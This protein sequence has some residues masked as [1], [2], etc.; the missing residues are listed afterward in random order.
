MMKKDVSLDSQQYYYNISSSFFYE[1]K[2][3]IPFKNKRLLVADYNQVV[4]VDAETYPPSSESVLMEQTI[5]L[6]EVETVFGLT[7]A[8]ENFKR[9]FFT[10]AMILSTVG[11]FISIM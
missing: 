11:V 7:L 5:A 10:G 1:P 2:T 8:S 6:F 4:I 3:I 9:T